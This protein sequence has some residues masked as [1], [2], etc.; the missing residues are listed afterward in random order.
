MPFDIYWSDYSNA[1]LKQ[2]ATH[3]L[4]NKQ[5]SQ[6][7]LA[8]AGSL[9]HTVSGTNMMTA[10]NGDAFVCVQEGARRRAQRT[11]EQGYDGWFNAAP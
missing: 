8:R 7:I 11:E 6:Q 3:F 9:E 2:R 1:Q 10:Q 5:T 4:G